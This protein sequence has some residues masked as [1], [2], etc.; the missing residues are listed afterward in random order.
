MNSAAQ[1]EIPGIEQ[2]D[3]FGS[4]AHATRHQVALTEEVNQALEHGAPVFMA[5]SG[6][7]DSQALAHRV[8]EHLD[9]IAHSGPR[10]M[11]HS[12][13]GR[14]EWRQSL[15]VCERLAERL[16]VE[17]LIVRRQAGDMMDR[18][19]SRWDANVARYVDLECVKLILPWSTPAT[20]F[21]TAELKSAVLARAMRK[22]FP[23]GDV[24]SAVGIRRE[25]SSTRARMPVWR[26]DPRTMRRAGVGHTWHPLLT[27]SR[28]DVLSYIKGRGD[29]LHEAYTIYGSS[30]VSCAF[31]IMASAHDLRAAASCGSNEAI[32]REMV[33]LEIRSTFS[34]Q[35]DRWLGDV[36]PALL[37]ATTRGRL[38]EA[39]ERAEDRK[40]AE[41]LLPES[42]LFVKGWPTAMPTPQEAQ[43]IAHV[44][45]RV[46]RAVGLHINYTEAP[47]VLARYAQL[48]AQ[49]A[50]KASAHGLALSA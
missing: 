36:A 47:E 17:L 50:A 26:Q 21:C 23:R 46:A 25:E 6:G 34:F 28:A 15:P 11:I 37:D 18:W 41:A 45:K 48:M 30:R 29:V 4:I 10:L 42:L 31:C 20:R 32:Y 38:M 14:V 7:K 13:L 27:W 24:I 9:A 33:E 19:L 35:G 1:H 16:G 43:L 39:K 3:L 49:A 22:R 44:R 8:C 2:L 12:D 40:R 5:V